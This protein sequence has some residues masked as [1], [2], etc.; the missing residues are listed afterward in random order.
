[1]QQKM[2]STATIDRHVTWYDTQIL[3]QIP[4]QFFDPEWHQGQGA[5]LGSATGRGNAHFLRYE[6]RELVLRR[7]H[8]GGLIGKFNADLYLRFGATA[9]RSYREYHL[10]A[11]MLEHDLPVPR[12][13]AARYTPAGLCYRAD[14]ITERIPQ[15]RPLADV[16]QEKALTLETWAKTGA[17]VRQM[18]TLGVDHSDLNCCNILVDADMQVWLIDFDK[19]RRR[20]AGRWRARNLARL[21]RSLVKERTKQPALFWSDADWAALIAGY[22]AGD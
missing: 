9:S 8:R 14:L 15:A 17:V 18:H 4:P 19:C 21:K 10:L 13:V 20:A 5:V 3:P 12:P 16:V 11:W 6:G 1:M 22:N 7:F 2:Q